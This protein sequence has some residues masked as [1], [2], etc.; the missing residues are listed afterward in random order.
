MNSHDPEDD[1][2]GR[3]ER[4][5]EVAQWDGD[6]ATPSGQG[7]PTSVLRATSLEQ[8][9]VWSAPQAC[10]HVHFVDTWER[11]WRKARRAG[12]GARKPCEKPDGNKGWRLCE[13]SH[14]VGMWNGQRGEEAVGPKGAG[15]EQ[16][17]TQSGAIHIE[18]K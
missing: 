9:R 18:K 1:G 11:H 15:G 17:R 8:G 5:E 14:S 4:S 2:S 3:A 16:Q 10:R 13:C 7:R 6:V 12:N